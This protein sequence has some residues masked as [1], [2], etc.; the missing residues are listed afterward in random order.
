MLKKELRSSLLKKRR[1]MSETEWRELTHG[2]HF[3][4]ECVL[5]HLNDSY[6]SN[7]CFFKA[8]PVECNKLHG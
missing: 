7:P 1:S 6:L 5:T 3:A 4:S 2:N 8:L